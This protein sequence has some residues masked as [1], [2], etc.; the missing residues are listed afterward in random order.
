MVSVLFFFVL[1]FAKYFFPGTLAFTAREAATSARM[2]VNF[3]EVKAAVIVDPS[4]RNPPAFVGT[5]RAVP[6]LLYHGINRT[7]SDISWKTFRNQLFAL[8]RAGWT[9]VTLKD[10][11]AFLHQGKSLPEKSFL[12]TFDDG[13]R[14]SWIYGDPVLKALDYTAVLFIITKFSTEDGSSY[15]L[16]RKEVETMLASNRWE[17]QSHGRQAHIPVV[18]DTNG[19]K[20]D[21]LSNR[22]WLPS[23]GRLET[24]EEFQER[25]RIDFE[26]SYR[27]IQ[28]LGIQDPIAFAFPSGDFGQLTLNTENAQQ[29]VLQEIRAFYPFVNFFQ[30]WPSQGFTHNYPAESPEDVMIRRIIVDPS[31]DEQALLHRLAFGAEK[32]LPYDQTF[33]PSQGWVSV[34]GD[35][36]FEHDGMTI[37][38]SEKTTGGLSFL[39]GTRPWISYRTQATDVVIEKGSTF[40]LVGRYR[41]ADQYVSCTFS[42]EAVVLQVMNKGV[43][44]SVL[45]QK[46]TL[47]EEQIPFQPFQ[48]IS[49]QEVV[50]GIDERPILSVS[51]SEE[52]LAPTGGIG[53]KTWDPVVNN[54]S[55]H[56]SR[57]RVMPVEEGL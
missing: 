3:L 41:D 49:G 18:I 13:I 42:R 6:A 1:L 36:V 55:V 5:A 24:L 50:C 26:A 30:F 10:F 17:I 53:I 9:T 29:I 11:Y 32:S 38:A 34:W 35:Q 48:E 4:L 22:Q 52:H 39:D 25:I 23:L 12:L 45:S 14:S 28:S 7:A 21:F 31:W 44:D 57:I 20:G 47:V 54:T 16:S 27:D 8:K 56:L 33:D 43:E 19:T 51:L 37:S 2:G 46:T 40:S 15:Y